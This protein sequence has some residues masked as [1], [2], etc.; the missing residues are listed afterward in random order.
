MP[1]RK[2]SWIRRSSPSGRSSAPFPL[3]E[4]RPRGVFSDRRVVPQFDHLI[5]LLHL[6]V[7][8]QDE[9]EVQRFFLCLCGPSAGSQEQ[10]QRA[11]ERQQRQLVVATVPSLRSRLPVETPVAARVGSRSHRSVGQ[12]LAQRRSLRR[13]QARTP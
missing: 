8:H 2:R 6:P 4:R 10:C 3:T 11:E 1:S 13:A 9:D 5:Q 12:V 7:V